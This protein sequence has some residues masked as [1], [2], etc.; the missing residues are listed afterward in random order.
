M[1]D[2]ILTRT[3]FT[4]SDKEDRAARK[5]S[6]VKM[7]DDLVR[8][9][10]H[11]VTG[12]QAQPL[13]DTGVR[14]AW[15]LPLVIALS[16]LSTALEGAGIG[17]LIPLLGMLIG[18]GQTPSIAAPLQRLFDSALGADPEFRLLRTAA[19][20]FGLI[21][22]KGVIQ[23]L[24]ATLVAW[25][26]G[27]V[28]ADIRAALSAR[29]LE[30]GFP[31]FLNQDAA[32][33]VNIVS[34]DSWRASDGLRMV[35]A[36]AAAT[37]ALVV[38]CALLLIINL[39]LF[40]LVLGG[41]VLIRGLQAV[42]SRRMRRLGDL[43][44]LAN[45]ELAERMLLIVTS[46]RLIRLFGQEG[47]EQARFVAA[48]DGVYRSM[49]GVQKAGA[50]VQPILEILQAAL[51]IVVLL[52]AHAM[53]LAVPTIASFLVLLYRMQPHV[54]TI[55]QSRLNLASLRG[56]IR[57]IEWLLGP[58]DKPA[59][60][61]GATDV[62][63]DG[64]SIRFENVSYAFS[65]RAAEHP[66]LQDVSFEL[67]PNRSTALI[68]PSG[69][70]KSTLVNLLCRLIEPSSGVI[71]IGDV[72]L[73]TVD[74]E[75]WRRQISVAGQD[76]DLVEDTIRENIAY[77]MAGASMEDVERA[78][79]I[80]GAHEFIVQIP[81]AYEARVGLRGL[82]LS[83]GQRQRIGLARAIIRKP[84][85]LILDE[86]TNAVDGVA[87]SAILRLLQEHRNFGAAIVISH[88]RSTLLACE[89]GVVID[90][91]RI[92]ETGALRDLKFYREMEPEWASLAGAPGLGARAK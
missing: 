25:A 88:R 58:D 71:R 85:L 57:E 77:G 74:P 56:S 60:Q 59:A 22:L 92:I 40:L 90:N 65:G 34:S 36:V 87:E 24:S 18:D 15:T 41:V 10:L 86:A 76:I 68:G 52:S 66:A 31:F 20:I 14:Y 38:F 29:M 8:R 2:L 37:S 79:R 48:S 64:A 75:M 13:L 35:Y 5:R 27:R 21:A 83:G 47:R 67:R 53:D 33:L 61:T 7:F 44:S 51:F 91:G 84:A 62:Q 69:A 50:V 82:S 4:A 81:E 55:N 1:H 9:S 32:R 26:E 39:P 6:K 63:M 11:R 43:V 19:V 17:L 46:I 80:A 72:E 89:D 28:A 78:A 3:E 54:S 16:L 23:M 12:L 42:Y 73:N 30:L 49:F 45:R 70:G